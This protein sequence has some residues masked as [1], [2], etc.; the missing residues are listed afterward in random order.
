[1][2]KQKYKEKMIALAISYLGK[3]NAKKKS[4]DLINDSKQILKFYGKRANRIID[5]T[6]FVISR[7]N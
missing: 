6:N 7:N 2:N 4:E 1:M 5:L 3:E